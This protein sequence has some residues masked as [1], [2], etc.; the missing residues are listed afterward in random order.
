[1]TNETNGP[2][3]VDVYTIDLLSFFQLNRVEKRKRYRRNINIRVEFTIGV[4]RTI[5]AR[6]PLSNF[7]GGGTCESGRL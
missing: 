7:A 5:G 2:T 6:K 1:M 4:L 3:Q